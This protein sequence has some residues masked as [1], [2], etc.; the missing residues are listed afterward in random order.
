MQFYNVI[1]IIDGSN[2]E[3][4]YSWSL[5]FILQILRENLFDIHSR[6]ILT[7]IW[8]IRSHD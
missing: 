5:N 3:Y 4:K 6:F 1:N 7:L 2:D 8:S